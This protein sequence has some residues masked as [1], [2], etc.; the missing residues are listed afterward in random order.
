MPETVGPGPAFYG[1]DGVG[2][3]V[4]I[5]LRMTMQTTTTDVKK[6]N[7]FS[8]HAVREEGL[9]FLICLRGIIFFER[10]SPPICPEVEL[11][12]LIF[13]ADKRGRLFFRFSA[14]IKCAMCYVAC[15]ERKKH[16]RYKAHF[17]V[18]C[19]SSLYL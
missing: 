13:F 4:A 12:L 19:V 9:V 15:P 5:S 8:V 1:A 16:T 6:T 7:M 10:T 11:Q 17:V 2:V 14:A 18:H 3:G